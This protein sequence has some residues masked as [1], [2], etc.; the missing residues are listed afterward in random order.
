CGSAGSQAA[1]GLQFVLAWPAA[2]SWP[3]VPFSGRH[4][5]ARLTG[6]PGEYSSGSIDSRAD[7]TEQRRLAASTAVFGA[8]TAISRV[9]GVVREIVAASF[10][11]SSPALGA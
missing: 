8:A 9:A 11:G 6:E 10:F 4:A 5:N 1:D 3:P 7:M 2:S